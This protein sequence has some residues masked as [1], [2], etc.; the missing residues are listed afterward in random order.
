MMFPYSTVI[1][2]WVTNSNALA[3]AGD[4][5]IAAM[6]TKGVVYVTSL[7][8]SM[9]HFEKFAASI[10]SNWPLFCISLV[11]AIDAG[12]IVWLLVSEH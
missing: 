8:M 10:Y 11:L 9:V 4:I 12:I 1:M 5:F 7:D 2:P 6:P 3:T